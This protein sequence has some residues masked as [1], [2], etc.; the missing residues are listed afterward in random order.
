M[1]KIMLCCLL[2]AANLSLQAQTNDFQ[3]YFMQKSEEMNRAYEKRD[4]SKHEA[5]VKEVVSRVNALPQAERESISRTFENIYYNLAC[6]YA[7]TGNS[8]KA[9]DALKKSNFDDYKQLKVDTDLDRLRGNPEFRKILQA[10]REKSDFVYI[11]QHS[12]GYSKAANADI[13]S[14]SYQSP[15]AEKLKRLKERYDLDSIA[16]NGHDETAVINLM[17]WV[18]YQV[19]HDGSKALPDKRNA[20][21]M[22]KECKHDGMSLNCR[23]LATILNEVYLA[24]GYQ[25]RMVTCMPKDTNDNDCHVINIVYMPY[26]RKWVWMDP[27]FMAYVMD[28]NGNLLSIEEV[29]D[30]IIRNKPL[31][32]N[33]DAN[34]NAGFRQQ[35]SWYLDNYMAKNLYKLQCA[36]SSEYDYETRKTGKKRTYVTLVPGREMKNKITSTNADGTNTYTEYFTSDPATFWAPPAGQRKSDFETVMEQFVA[37]YNSRNDEAIR[38]TFQNYEEIKNSFWQDGNAER[39]AREYGNIISAKFMG[40]STE[41]GV[42]LFKIKAEKKTFAFGMSLNKGKFENFRFHTSSPEIDTMLAKTN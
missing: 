17:R 10:A 35:K 18:H 2:L 6:T 24:A 7:L 23:G 33:A 15:E 11:L 37:N 19:P 21:S 4:A 26:K 22:L 25:S 14:F 40:F 30:R 31:I 1:R 8:K 41:D 13:P 29:R 42:A 12:G 9:I 34:R 3:T 32:M 5:L 36:V 39:L 16:G 38:Q 28:E 20:L 27:T